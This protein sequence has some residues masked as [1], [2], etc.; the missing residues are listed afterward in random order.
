MEVQVEI[1]RQTITMQYG[2]LNQGDILRTNPA[3]A[4]HLVDDC[5][6]AKYSRPAATQQPAAALDVLEAQLVVSAADGLAP[7]P[8]D[9]DTDGA[10]GSLAGDT[11]AIDAGVAPTDALPSDGGA[12]IDGTVQTSAQGD[13]GAAAEPAGPAARKSRTAARKDQ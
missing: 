5:G 8:P 4:A 3:F 11:P 1:L 10:A 6:S 13:E 12:D 9:L 7:A 2:T